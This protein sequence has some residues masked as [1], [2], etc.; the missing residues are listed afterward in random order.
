MIEFVVERLLNLI[1]TIAVMGRDRRE[2][3]DNALRAISHALNETYLYYRDIDAG[4]ERNID[5][6]AQLS[7][8]W[9]AAAIPL[10][11]ID[12]ELAQICEYKSEYWVNPESWDSSKVEQLGI[13]LKDVRERYR[14]LLHPKRMIVEKRK[15]QTHHRGWSVP[16]KLDSLS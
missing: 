4:K 2:L 3:R 5:T 11:H 13:G 7:R 10:R 14:N 6:E 16:P 12:N 1:G 9:S 8:Y 15:P